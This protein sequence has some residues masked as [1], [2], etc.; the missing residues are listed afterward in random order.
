MTI[1]N[2]YDEC[3]EYQREGMKEF[4]L[5]IWNATTAKLNRARLQNPDRPKR[6]PL[7][8]SKRNALYAKQ[9]GRCADCGESFPISQLTDDHHD[10]NAGAN[11]NDFRN[12]RLVCRPCN[13]SKNANS[14]I[15]EAQRKGKTIFQYVHEQNELHGEDEE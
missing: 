5:G 15:E 13:S 14:V 1:G 3:E 12:R 6:K 11:Y 8:P 10:P 4:G 9:G 2:R 7:S